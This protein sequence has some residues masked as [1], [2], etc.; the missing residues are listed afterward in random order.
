MATASMYFILL[1]F[2]ILNCAASKF[3]IERA[4]YG[5]GSDSM[6]DEQRELY[7]KRE[8]LNKR[9]IQLNISYINS[10]AKDNYNVYFMG[11][12]LDVIGSSSFKALADGYAKDN[13]NVYYMGKKLGVIGTSSFTVLKNGYAKDSYNVYYL[14][15]KM[16]VISSSSFSVL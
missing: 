13:Y 3:N 15:Q 6:D 4:L 10:Y 9:E 8:V 2:L 7:T 16:D 5:D 1:S 14:G 11:K 12:K